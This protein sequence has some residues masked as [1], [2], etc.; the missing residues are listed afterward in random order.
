MDAVRAITDQNRTVMVTIHQPSP[1]TFALFDTVLLLAFGK[2]VY[3]GEMV[4]VKGYFSDP[5]LNYHYIKALA[6]ALVL[7]PTLVLTLTLPDP[8]WS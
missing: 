5:P 8:P 1:E 6:L 3:F 2:V 4:K 7:T